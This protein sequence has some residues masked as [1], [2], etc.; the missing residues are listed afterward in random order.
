[1]HGRLFIF[2][3]LLLVILTGFGVAAEPASALSFP[4]RPRVLMS[5]AELKSLQTEPGRA[6]ERTQLLARADKILQ[7]GLTVPVKEGNWI[8]YYACPD[9]GA[10]LRA[11]TP[12]RHSCPVCKR[13]FTDERTA[14]AYR[15]RLY[16]ALEQDLKALATAYAVSGE[17][18]YAA[19]GRDALLSLARTWPT[20]TRHDRWGR[21]GLLAVVGGRRF[22]QLLDE[23][24]SLINLA[25]VWD[26]VCTAPCFSADDRA[27]IE[28]QLFRMPADELGAFEFFTGSRNNHQTWF[29]AAYAVTGLALGDEPLLRRALDGDHGLRWQL[30]TSITSDGLWYEGALAYHFYAL[31]AIMK[32]LEAAR[33]AGLSLS[34]DQ[35]LKSLWTGPLQMAYPNGQCPVFH[36]SDPASLS[37]YKGIFEWGARYFN[38]PALAAGDPSRLGS[39]NLAGI[40]VAVLRRGKGDS[41]ACLMMD[42]GQ[43]GDGHG[44]PDKLNVVLYGLGREL[45]LDPGRISYSVPEYKTWCRTTVAH[46][47]VVL[48]GR[49]QKPDCGRLLFFADTP[50]ASAALA[51]SAGAYDGAVLRRFLILTDDLLIDVY[52]VSR[53]GKGRVDWLLHGRGELAATPGLAPRDKALDGTDGYAHLTRLAEGVPLATPASFTFSLGTAS[54]WRV[55]T[56]DA[57][58][59]VRFF[60][61][62]GIGYNTADRVP[63]LLRRHEGG[64]TAFATV[65]D[66]SG[67]GIVTNIALLPVREANAPLPP[68]EAAAVRVDTAA[69]SRLFA[70]DFSDD[71]SRELTVLNRSFKRW[72]TS[73][74]KDCE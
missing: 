26:L 37:N 13:V 18:K 55:W 47:T 59:G 40:G 52:A 58:P 31:Q 69:G 74:T 70:M 56:A 29:N 7:N 63:F 3:P 38:D 46:N 48:D 2:T 53:H 8:F 54:C 10:D 15:T 60:T 36:D 50:A 4:P 33:T 27:L 57:A 17:V 22:C 65:Y 30:K 72:L 35:T 49:D 25:G 6:A 68:E 1:M 5:A 34:A 66:L 21:T 19:P 12:D 11:E 71:G 16:N 73:E 44:H 62:M 45:L 64:S 20:L 43:H 24:V 51:L 9:D 39:T 61:G 28:K 23:A 67:R 32:T 42:Y 41:A 14:A